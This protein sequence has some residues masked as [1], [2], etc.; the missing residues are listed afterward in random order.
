MAEK[1]ITRQDVAERRAD[2]DRQVAAARQ[3]IADAEAVIR[4]IDGAIQENSYYA[5]LLA[6]QEQAPPKPE[7]RSQNPESESS[8]A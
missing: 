2:L 7:S 6:G 5:Q 3:R 4:A 1:V 8:G